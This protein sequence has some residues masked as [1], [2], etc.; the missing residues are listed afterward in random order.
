[1]IYPGANADI[2]KAYDR[3]EIRATYKEM[4]NLIIRMNAANKPVSLI[5]N[6]NPD[7]QN[8]IS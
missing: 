3:N 6:E 4:F 5:V 7:I 1:M 2:T 8:S